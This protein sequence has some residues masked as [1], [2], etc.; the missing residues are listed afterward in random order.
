MKTYSLVLL[1]IIITSL[2]PK[3]QTPTFQAVFNNSQGA[4]NNELFSITA[5]AMGDVYFCGTHTDSLKLGSV[6]LLPGEG[7]AYWGKASATGTVLWLKQGG[8]SNASSDKAYDIAV[9]LNG[10]IY[11]CGVIAGFQVASFNGTPLPAMYPGFVVKYDNLGNFIWAQ[12]YDAN[13]YSIAIDN[14]NIPVINYGDNTI[15]KI[16]PSDGTLNMTVSGL[17]SGNL[18]N[19]QWHNIEID[20]NNNI[21]VQAG[22]K[23]VKFDNNLTQLWSTPITS[24]LIETFR[25]SLDSQGNVYSTFYGLFGSV[26]VGTFTKTDF[27]NGYLFKLD[28]GTG[29]PIFCDSIRINSNASKIKEVLADNAGN[30]YVSGDGAF[31][32]AF[33]GKYSSN[34]APIW[35]KTF[36]SN[37]SVND[38]HLVSEDCLVE[39]GKHDGTAIFDSYTLDLPNGATTGENSYVAS[40]C[41]GTVSIGDEIREAQKGLIF[42]N[43][44]ASGFRIT[45]L[46][47]SEVLIIDFLGQEVYQSGESGIEHHIDDLTPGVYSIII[48]ETTGL[49][50]CFRLI[51]E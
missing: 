37:A 7:G 28:N 41:N 21:I 33:I 49:K 32:T 6:S 46:D 11:I 14:N 43:P 19:S 5:D 50:N 45:G 40:L 36:S 13:I 9:D 22:N 3:A 20:G 48:T 16:D 30:Y 17:F 44:A 8:S 12:G 34:Y 38:M 39:C 4:Q 25:L 2:T 42:P 24:S 18:Q 15:Y 47:Y 10:D 23:I 1:A 26:T 51:K 27:P 31:N 35:G 29:V